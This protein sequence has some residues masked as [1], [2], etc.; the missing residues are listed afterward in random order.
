MP[1]FGGVGFDAPTQRPG[2]AVTHGAGYG[3]GAG[4]EA[5]AGGGINPA[6]G[7]GAMT[8]LLTRLSQQDTTGLLGRLLQSAQQRNA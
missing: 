4:L 8:Q 7:T 6:R 3:P 1:A 2:E 5:I